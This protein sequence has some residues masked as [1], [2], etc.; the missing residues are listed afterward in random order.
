MG[1][2]LFSVLVGFSLLANTALLTVFLLQRGA[3]P[4]FGQ[5][6]DG[7]GRFSLGTEKAADQSPICFVISDGEPQLLVYR[8]DPAG[9]LQLTNSREITW[10]PEAQGQLLPRRQLPPRP[11]APPRR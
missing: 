9:Q 11:C 7:G 10:G 2:R 3:A 4:A 6:A 1:S 5:T 8:V